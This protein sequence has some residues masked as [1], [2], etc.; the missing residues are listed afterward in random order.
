LLPW[1]PIAFGTGIALYFAAEHEPVAWVAAATA[2]LLCVAAFLLRRQRWF[3]LIL[4]IAAIAA[5]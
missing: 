5:R 1:V 3:P 4:L 2:G